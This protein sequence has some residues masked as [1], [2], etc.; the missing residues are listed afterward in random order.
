MAALV[1][2]R[3]SLLFSVVCVP[4][5]ATVVMIPR[6]FTAFSQ[7]EGWDVQTAIR[8]LRLAQQLDP[9]VGHFELADLYFHIGL[10]EQA[11]AEYEL[12]LKIDPDNNEFKGFYINIFYDSARPDEALEASQRFLNRG[13]DNRYYLEKM[14]VREAAP[15]IE[16]EYQKDPNREWI[17]GRRA[18]LLALQ[19]KHREAVAAIPK[20]TRRYRG[21]HHRTYD[22]ARVYALAGKS[23]QALKWLRVTV[24]DGFP[25]YPLFARDPFL[26]PIRNDP[27]FIQFLAEMKERWEGYRREFG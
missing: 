14:M 5:P 23:E 24:S 10:E 8:E 1:A 11:I 22:A 15:L 2:G 18:L 19:G 12:A 16:E 4:P 26:D 21:Y 25:C 3:P 17:R 7:Y 6:G 9:N 13:P 20:K 27:A